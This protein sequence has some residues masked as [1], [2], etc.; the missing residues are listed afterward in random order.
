MPFVVKVNN[1]VLKN[2]CKDRALL[3]KRNI[4]SQKVIYDEMYITYLPFMKK[5]GN[6][7]NISSDS[8]NFSKVADIYD[9]LTVDRFLGRPFPPNI[10][11]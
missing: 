6:I 4:D 2:Y 11:E 7:F 3:I 5:L 9:T 10:T 1:T 8:M